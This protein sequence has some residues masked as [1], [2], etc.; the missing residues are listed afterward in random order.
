MNLN[1]L[2][3][4]RPPT[5]AEASA[6]VK[7]RQPG[8]PGFLSQVGETMGTI[9]A[10]VGRTFGTTVTAPVAAGEGAVNLVGRGAEAV[11]TPFY[12]VGKYMNTFRTPMYNVLGGKWFKEVMR[13]K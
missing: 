1:P 2:N 8:Q 3:F 10:A 5:E 4:F 13:G 9:A 7:N 6:R 11:A 12:A